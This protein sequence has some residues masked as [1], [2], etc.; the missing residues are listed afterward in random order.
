MTEHKRNKQE[1]QTRMPFEQIK[2]DPSKI[3]ERLKKLKKKRVIVNNSLTVVSFALV[4]DAIVLLV[5]YFINENAVN[6]NEDRILENLQGLYMRSSKIIA[7]NSKTN[8]IS[9]K[10][11]AATT[12]FSL[13]VPNF[14]YWGSGIKEF[15]ERISANI[16]TE[17]DIKHL[18]DCIVI[19]SASIGN[20]FQRFVSDIQKNFSPV[21]SRG[22]QEIL[23]EIGEKIQQ[24][25]K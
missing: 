20:A 2:Y 9:L 16:Y 24:I 21:L 3:K 7:A 10:E 25:R 18:W 6:F 1:K 13:M 5:W 15:I 22:F 12:F 14:L 19:N 8:L 4:I 17:H 23:A 11:T